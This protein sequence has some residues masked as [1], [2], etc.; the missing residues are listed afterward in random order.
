MGYAEVAVNSPI[1]Q[2]RTFSYTIPPH[3]ALT[4]GQAVWVPFG[5][6]VLQGIVF[7]LTD[8]PA[9]EETREIAGLIDPDPLLTSIQIKLARWISEYYLAPLFDAAALMLPPGF[10]RKLVTFFQLSPQ[11]SPLADASLIPEQKQLLKRLE[12]GRVSLEAV[13]KVL[14][15]EKARLVLSQLLR[16]GLVTKSQELEKVKV[17][18]KF[19]P[20][21]CLAVGAEVAR[22][23]GQHLASKALAPISGQQ[24][25]T[26]F[27][28]GSEE[29]DPLHFGYGKSTGGQ[30]AG[31]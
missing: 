27:A 8:Y 24:E 12:K 6:K 13:E 2:R 25:T 28:S 21:L 18:P 5:S 17:K 9:V 20:Y 1:A 30:G 22:E 31:S 15:K 10:E 19:L 11:S 26:R 7:D 29:G 3:L 14:G 4:P 16:K 23:E